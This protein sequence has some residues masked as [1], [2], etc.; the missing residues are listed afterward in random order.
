M[1][2]AISPS[3]VQQ[4]HTKQG[5]QTGSTVDRK[6]EEQALS[7]YSTWRKSFSR[8]EYLAFDHLILEMKLLSRVKISSSSVLSGV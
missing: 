3:S 2:T 7:L 5:R 4:R 8:P 1:F 6:A